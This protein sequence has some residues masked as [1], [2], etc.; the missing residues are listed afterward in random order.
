MIYGCYIAPLAQV[1]KSFPLN[2]IRK[3]NVLDTDQIEDG[4]VLISSYTIPYRV[5]LK[6]S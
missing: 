4:A 3:I 1:V 2:M 5:P 6:Q